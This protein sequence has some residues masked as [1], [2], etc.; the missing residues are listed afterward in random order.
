[1]LKEYRFDKL[2][3]EERR[4]ERIKDKMQNLRYDL[5]AT[6]N[7]VDMWKAMLKQI[8]KLKK[9]Q[10]GAKDGKKRKVD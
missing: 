10:K 8:R 3:T 4:V 9:Q 7:A 5:H 1:M 2:A 6:Q